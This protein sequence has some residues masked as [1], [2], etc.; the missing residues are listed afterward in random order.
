[1]EVHYLA[2]IL[3]ILWH[4][5]DAIMWTLAPNTQKCLKEELHANVLVAGEYDV[6]EVA[7]Q[8]VD[9]IVSNNFLLTYFYWQLKVKIC[10][11]ICQHPTQSSNSPPQ[12]SFKSLSLPTI[13]Y[14][15][16]C[17][18]QVIIE[19]SDTNQ[20]VQNYDKSKTSFPHTH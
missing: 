8:R 10:N 5:T 11:C 19:H 9:Y 6:P 12:V 16:F 14:L 18:S 20:N 2:L 1:M 4:S 13:N 15:L 3:S 17:P 7:G